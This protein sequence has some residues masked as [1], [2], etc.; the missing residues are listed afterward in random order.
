MG[1]KRGNQAVS[2]PGWRQ[3][4]K[5]AFGF[6][7]Q[8]PY[9]WTESAIRVG[10]RPYEV[11]RFELN[12]EIRRNCVVFRTP[13]AVGL[14]PERAADEAKR[15]ME[16]N[17]YQHFVMSKVLVHGYRAVSVE[18]DTARDPG[19]WSRRQYYVPI[20]DDVLVFGLAS[21]DIDSDNTLFD[22]IAAKFQ[23][24]AISD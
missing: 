16:S 21:S 19:L 23:I 1:R 9:D 18:C 7:L 4:E 10:Q 22:E 3:I 20:G 24:T 12:G 15:Y 5:P 6:A 14:S 2:M 8:I 13:G 17:G 11:A